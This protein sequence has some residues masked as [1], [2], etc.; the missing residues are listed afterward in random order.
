M[1]DNVSGDAR[2]EKVRLAI[3]AVRRFNSARYSWSGLDD[4]YGVDEAY[5]SSL[6]DL[7]LDQIIGV[8]RDYP[9][10]FIA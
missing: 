9:G 10:P 4:L 7:A 6:P 8:D 3:A 5:I 1:P 2:A